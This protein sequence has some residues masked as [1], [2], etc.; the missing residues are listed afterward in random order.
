MFFVFFAFFVVNSYPPSQSISQIDA[1]KVWHA[2]R[3]CQRHF[4]T[5]LARRTCLGSSSRIVLVQGAN[6][7][8]LPEDGRGLL[9]RRENSVRQFIK[10]V[11]PCRFLRVRSRFQPFAVGGR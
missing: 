8:K 7:V 5:L 9:V 2:P 10:L 4:A 11:R 6:W 3:Q 1:N